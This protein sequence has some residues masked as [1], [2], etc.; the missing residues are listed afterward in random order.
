MKLS[1]MYVCGMVLMSACNS[2]TQT[3]SSSNTSGGNK[4][5]TSSS[6]SSVSAASSVSLPTHFAYVADNSFTIYQFNLDPSTGQMTEMNPTH[7][8]STGSGGIAESLCSVRLHPNGKL[9]IAAN[10]AANSISPFTI[11]AST[12]ALS[13]VNS[14]VIANAISTTLST[15]TIH[16]AQFAFDSTGSNIY[17]AALKNSNSGGIYDYL[18]KMSINSSTGAIAYVNTPV[19]N[20]SGQDYVG[21]YLSTNNLTLSNDLSESSGIHT[22]TINTGTGNVDQYD[23]GSLSPYSSTLGMNLTS[24][25]VH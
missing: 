22:Y 1:K 20:V 18:V 12:G 19:A 15:T 9:L 3:V 4:T 21:T 25:V 24:I 16:L 2:S 8:V 5:S 6:V 13:P 11:D 14:N 7:S 17:V 23:S 10:C